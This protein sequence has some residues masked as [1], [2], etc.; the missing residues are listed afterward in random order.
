[1]ANFC[2]VKDGR[3]TTFGVLA[4][5]LIASATPAAGSTWDGETDA[6]WLTG[7]NWNGNVAPSAASAVII[8]DG[9]LANQPLLGA[10]DAST[11]ASLALSAG[12]LT[13]AGDLTATNGVV[14]GG[15]GLLVGDFGT[16]TGNVDA[17]GGT[18]GGT[19]SI[20]GD[21]VLGAPS[22]VLF[23][24][25]SPGVFDQIA[26]NGNATLGGNLVIDIGGY[27]GA[28]DV[29]FDLL[30]FD[31]RTPGSMFDSWSVGELN[32]AVTSLVYSDTGVLLQIRSIAAVPEPETWAML[33]LGFGMVGG[34]MR[35]RRDTRARL[36]TT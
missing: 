22:T 23:N 14:L 4:L 5:G 3:S 12:V 28:T 24:I 2:W 35:T 31:S 27:N 20:L 11:I 13:L 17:T 25:Y 15:A 19:L 9:G 26:I 7:T 1:M 18:I 36:A 8:D 16:L 29:A 32:G 34:A 30:T 33:I 21:V 10:G 6:D